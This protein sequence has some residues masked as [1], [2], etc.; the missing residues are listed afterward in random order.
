MPAPDTEEP[1]PS[2]SEEENASSRSM[3]GWCAS[4]ASL[5]SWLHITP[6]ETMATRLERSQPPGL[7]SSARRIG[8]AKASPTMAMLVTA[9]RSM[10]SSS[11]TASK[12]R[13]CSVT[14]E[15]P[16]ESVDSPGKLPVPCICGHAGRNRAPGSAYQPRMSS[17]V[18]SSGK[19]LARVAL[20]F[21]T[22]SSWRHMTPFG[23]PVVP[24]V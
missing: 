5:D 8:L 13:P 9:S 19:A 22:R 16:A 1:M 2:A 11:S 15:P 14:T 20:S 17:T 21:T 12:V 7:A 10:V 24:P 6:E 18:P 23:M 4:R 3:P